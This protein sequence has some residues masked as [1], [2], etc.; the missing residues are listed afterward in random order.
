MP[1]SGFAWSHVG[2]ALQPS[3]DLCDQ[4]PPKMAL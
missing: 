2:Y 1:S 4:A 3:A